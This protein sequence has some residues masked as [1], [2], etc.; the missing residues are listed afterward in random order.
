MHLLTGSNA[1]LVRFGSTKLTSPALEIAS[2]HYLDFDPVGE[3]R[4]EHNGGETYNTDRR[5]HVATGTETTRGVT[6]WAAFSVPRVCT[7]RK[8]R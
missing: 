8:P 2:Y 5:R 3:E 6:P 7:L 1:I 4:A